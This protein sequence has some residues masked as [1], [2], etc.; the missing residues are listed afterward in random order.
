MDSQK[1][2]QSLSLLNLLEIPRDL[3]QPLVFEPYPKPTC[4]N[5]L[6]IVVNFGLV[7]S[8]KSLSSNYLLKDSILD[9]ATFQTPNRGW[10]DSECPTQKLTFGNTDSL[11]IIDTIGFD[12]PDNSDT[13]VSLQIFE[14]IKTLL[15][16]LYLNGFLFT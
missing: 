11:L 12:A 4:E 10:F 15:A 9:P 5:Y 8:G 3:L 6:P 2:V 14:F 13:L 16:D 1:Q 7:G